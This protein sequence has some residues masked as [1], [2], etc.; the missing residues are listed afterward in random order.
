MRNDDQARVVELAAEGRLA[1]HEFL[2]IYARA[3][4]ALGAEF[5]D[6]IF[7]GVGGGYADIGIEVGDVQYKLVLTTHK[8][9]KPPQ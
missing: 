2:D 4:K 9:T 7:S 5:G 3:C 8:S 6:T 1:D